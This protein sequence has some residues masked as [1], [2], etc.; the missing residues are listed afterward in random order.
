MTIF[1]ETTVFL[2]HITTLEAGLF[3]VSGATGSGKSTTLYTLLDSINATQQRNIV[4]LEDP[5]EIKKEY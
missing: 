4:T 3:I 5:V 1:K 2:K